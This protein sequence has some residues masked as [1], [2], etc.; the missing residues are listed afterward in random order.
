MNLNEQLFGMA[1][2]VELPLFI[3]KIEFDKEMGE[4]H[5]HLDFER[6]SRFNCDMCSADGC[7]VSDTENKTWRHLN[8]FQ[9][10]CYLHLR[11]PYINCTDCGN[12]LFVPDWGRT[13][14]GF[15][16]LFEAFILTLAREMPISA[17]AET[18]D[19]HD[20]RLWRII[21]AH[22]KKAYSKKDFSELKKVGIDE[23]STRKG[24]KYVSVFIDHDKKE[25]VFATEGKN[26]ETIKKFAE[27]LPNHNGNAEN[28]TAVSMDMST[29]FIAGAKSNLPN[30]TITFDKFHVVKQLNEAID[31]VRREEQKIN[32]VLKGS[33]YI[34]LKN[35]NNLTKKQQNDLHTLAKENKKL[36]RA[37]QMKLTFQDIYR[38]VKDWRFA[39]PPDYLQKLATLN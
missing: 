33:R 6:G 31:Q 7:K 21:N 27:E 11:T 8:F 16:L 4:L 22:V 29:A 15:T 13:R 23:T 26:A 9:Y 32:P 28:V 35:P 17:I 38:T 14:S 24:H 30:A 1:L 34:W 20:T 36:A 12:H 39:I 19:E 2:G 3:D 5:I 18:V 37:Y 25:T 10:K